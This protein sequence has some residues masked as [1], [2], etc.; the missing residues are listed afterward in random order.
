MKY[1][2]LWGD[3]GVNGVIQ[4]EEVVFTF[5]TYNFRVKYRIKGFFGSL[6]KYYKKALQYDF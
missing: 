2:T 5:L 3:F 6:K 4:G 1:I